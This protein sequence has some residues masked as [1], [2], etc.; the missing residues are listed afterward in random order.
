MQTG[1]ILA[2][3]F[4]ERIA[5]NILKTLPSPFAMVDNDDETARYVYEECTSQSQIESVFA[6]LKTQ[7]G[8]RVENLRKP[9]SKKYQFMARER[10]RRRRANAYL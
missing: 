3:T 9:R 5:K 2:I 8:M 7:T 10:Q 4:N 1:E 6:C